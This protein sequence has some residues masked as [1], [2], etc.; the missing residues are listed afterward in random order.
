MTSIV[1]SDVSLE[2]GMAVELAD[3]EAVCRVVR[4][5]FDPEAKNYLIAYYLPR[6]HVAETNT[7]TVVDGR[8]CLA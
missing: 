5:I 4:S 3:G 8:L 2:D 6:S 1:T 7:L